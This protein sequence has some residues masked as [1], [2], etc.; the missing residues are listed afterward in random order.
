MANSS[1]LPLSQPSFFKA[2]PKEKEQNKTYLL[3]ALD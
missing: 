3:A 2:A 1:S